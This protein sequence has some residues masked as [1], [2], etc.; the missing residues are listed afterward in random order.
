MQMKSLMKS[1]SNGNIQFYENLHKKYFEKAKMDKS[2]MSSKP[3]TAS[4]FDKSGM[5]QITDNNLF[6]LTS[7]TNT[8]LGISQFK[9]TNKNVDDNKLRAS[10][11]KNKSALA[12]GDSN[13]MSINFKNSLFKKMNP[14][15]I[16]LDN[17]SSQ[18]QPNASVNR[19]PQRK[20]L[21]YFD[22]SSSSSS[23]SRKSSEL[24]L[25]DHTLK[26]SSKLQKEKKPIDIQ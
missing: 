13:T 20:R 15:S 14:N 1:F 6:T 2:K 26:N 4:Q 12:K 11:L 24:D 25:D 18:I 10:S 23:N 22:S 9:E 17:S 8:L 16:L 19:N 21:D 5:S 3:P 7:K